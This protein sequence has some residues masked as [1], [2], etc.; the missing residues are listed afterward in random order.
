VLLAQLI[1]VAVEAVVYLAHQTLFM[2]VMV[3]RVSLF[4]N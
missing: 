2:V 3:V 4:L 1:L